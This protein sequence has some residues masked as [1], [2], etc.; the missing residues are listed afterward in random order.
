MK[1]T[2]IVIDKSTKKRKTLY[3]YTITLEDGMTIGTCYRY[4]T[5]GEALIRVYN[6]LDITGATDA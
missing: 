1:A 2:N 6:L 4:E 3:R 5:V